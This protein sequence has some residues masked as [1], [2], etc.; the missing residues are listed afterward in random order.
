MGRGMGNREWGIEVGDC[1][2]PGGIPTLVRDNP[3]L[4]I[5]HSLFPIPY[6]H[7]TAS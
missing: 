4:P 7:P 3:R 5:P 1:L 2:L 6:S